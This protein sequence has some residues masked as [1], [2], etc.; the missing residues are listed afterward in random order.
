MAFRDKKPGLWM[1]KTGAALIRQTNHPNSSND[2]KRKKLCFS[3]GK[4]SSSG[5]F[6]ASFKW[7]PPL[8]GFQVSGK[9]AL[10]IKVPNKVKHEEGTKGWRKGGGFGFHV[11]AS[12]IYSLPS[13]SL[14]KFF[15]L[16]RRSPTGL[17]R[18]FLGPNVYTWTTETQ[19]SRMLGQQ[20]PLETI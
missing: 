11:S 19:R 2:S 20:G 13:Y 5:N 18:N 10:Y 17:F 8:E 16:A 9:R 6:K 1:L 7:K 4:L 3:L 15:T 14:N 12:F